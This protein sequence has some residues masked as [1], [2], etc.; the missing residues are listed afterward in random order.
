MPIRILLA[1]VIFTVPGQAADWPQ[2]RGPSGNG[3]S[4]EKNLPD[5]WSPTKNIRWKTPIPGLGHSS[6]IVWGN[7]VFLTTAIEGPMLDGAGAPTH[8]RQGK[9]WKHPDSLGADGAW[10]LKVLALDASSGKI[11]WQ[12]TSF[13]GAVFDNRHQH[14]SYASPTPVTDGK[15]VYVSF[16]AQ[17]I[18]AYDF[19][20]RKVWN[21]SIGKLGTLGLGDGTSP[22]LFDNLVIIQADED[23]GDN[24]VI[25]AFDKRT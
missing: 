25:V 16:G 2:W 8:I 13:E 9:A 10:T 14:G 17:G 11:L 20:G 4:A 12:Q 1:V 22:V 7:R 6:P 21:A 18:Y 15:N 23:S 5:E 3:I 24:S 19:E